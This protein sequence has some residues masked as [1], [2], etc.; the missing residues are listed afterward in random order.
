VIETEEA[1]KAV[2]AALEMLVEIIVAAVRG[3]MLL[4][5]SV[6][7]IVVMIVR[8][9]FMIYLVRDSIVYN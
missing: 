8:K 1:L 4:L 9:G 3:R 5:V 7:F 2:A 6:V